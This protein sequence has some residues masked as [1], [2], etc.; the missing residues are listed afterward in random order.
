MSVRLQRCIWAGGSLGQ[1]WAWV[2]RLPP[3]CWCSWGGC[4][5]GILAPPVHSLLSGG[6][7]DW[8]RLFLD[9]GESE[10]PRSCLTATALSGENLPPAL[11]F[12]RDIFAPRLW[13]LIHCFLV[14]KSQ[15]FIHL[16]DCLLYG[17]GWMWGF[18]LFTAKVVCWG[19]RMQ[20]V[21]LGGLAFSFSPKLVDVGGFSRWCCQPLAVCFWGRKSKGNCGVCCFYMAS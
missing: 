18:F 2:L 20:W 10:L 14:V 13:R 15:R 1:L 9:F 19:I 21:R 11:K 7:W 4:L 3:R 5:Q 17:H 16:L 8:D 12:E 6:Q